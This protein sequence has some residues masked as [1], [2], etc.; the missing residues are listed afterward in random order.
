VKDTIKTEPL[1]EENVCKDSVQQQTSTRPSNGNNSTPSA[2]K[3]SSK[4]Q[5]FSS[6]LITAIVAFIF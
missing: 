2:L 5:L 6:I 3:K 4:W 1:I